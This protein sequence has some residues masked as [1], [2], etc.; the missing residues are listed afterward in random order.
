M[1]SA[2]GLW[3]W[4][5]VPSVPLVL[6]A[7]AVA[8]SARVCVAVVLRKGTGAV[9][10]QSPATS[11]PAS[12]ASSAAPPKHIHQQTPPPATQLLQMRGAPIPQR[13]DREQPSAR[14]VLRARH[15][16]AQPRRLR[17]DLSMLPAGQTPRAY[18]KRL[19]EHYVTH[20][21]GYLAVERNCEQ[22]ITVELY[23]LR[24]GWTVFARYSK[25]LREEWVDQLLPDELSMFAERAV[26]ALLHDRSINDTIKRDTVLR[27]DTRLPKRWIGGTHHL[28]VALGTE[29]RGG[30]LP[31]AQGDGSSASELRL[32]F[33][34][35]ISGGYRGKFENWA[36]AS[37]AQ[38]ALAPGQSSTRSNALGGHVDLGGS[39]G[40]S[41]HFLHYLDPRG[42]TSFFA[43]AG[44]NFQLMWFNYIRA[45]S[46]AERRGVL[47]AGG[48]DVDLVFG[49][50]FMRASSI[51]WIIQGELH[52]PAYV[53]RAEANEGAINSWLPGATV[54]IGV[55]Y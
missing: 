36:I 41:L 26:L 23:P 14:R 44:G 29:L 18:L 48:L 54:R 45:E 2:C 7:A 3:L 1:K 15:L 20:E 34:M 32:A 35:S 27:A 11:Q 31:S 46:A 25:H 39:V 19:M 6:P 21:P 47:V 30:L 53:A 5:L 37:T 10:Q 49:W 8:K 55:L 4:F 9:K 52:L 22:K 43:G 33:P 17:T 38:L 40:V 12:R 13:D 24:R 28:V 51:Q 50:E 42:V 16:R